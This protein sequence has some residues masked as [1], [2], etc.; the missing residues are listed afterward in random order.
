[1]LSRRR[2]LQY[3]WILFY[4]ILPTITFAGHWDVQ[5]RFPGTA[6]TVGFAPSH[7]HASSAS[8]EAAAHSDHCHV[9]A[10]GC[11]DQPLVSGASVAHFRESLASAVV[12][13]EVHGY[14]LAT[15]VPPEG[16][17]VG[18]DLPPPRFG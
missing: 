8:G 3:A 10:A 6:T 18:P 2:R 1:M 14:F 17:S 4:A 16:A 5:V 13:G 15:L 9:D 7:T 12:M 11:S